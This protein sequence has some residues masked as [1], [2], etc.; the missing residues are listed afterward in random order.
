MNFSFSEG[1]HSGMSSISSGFVFGALV[2]GGFAAI[3][4]GVIVSRLSRKLL[5]GEKMLAAKLMDGQKHY[6]EVIAKHEKLLKLMLELYETGITGSLNDPRAILTKAVVD[7]ACA[8]VNAEAGSLMLMEAFT[9]KLVVSSV[10]GLPEELVNNARLA[11][12]EGIAGHVAKHGKPLLISD[13]KVNSRILPKHPEPDELRSSV[14]VPLKVKER[15]IGVLNVHTNSVEVEFNDKDIEALT[16]LAE[17]AAVLLENIEL[18]DNLQQFYFDIVQTLVQALDA[19]DSYTNEHAARARY[20]ARCV[21]TELGLPPSIVKYVEYAALMHDVGKIGVDD[22]I[23]RKPDRLTQSE[24]EVMKKHPEI[25]SKIL[26]PVSLLAPVAPMVLYHQEWYNGQG[27]PAGLSKGEIP[28]GAR[29]VA[30]IDAW[31]AMTT[32]RPYRKAMTLGEARDE[33]KKNAGT[34]FDPDVVA[35]FLQFID[36]YGL[37][38]M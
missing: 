25:G 12:G 10:K 14:S 26:S 32:D 3:I 20:Y 4:A 9:Q 15:V 7:G 35:A 38:P 30:I 36:R 1:I 27:Y 31:D 33:L 8:L 37:E 16:L 22:S 24:Y 34:Q 19:K 13:I 6:K 18:Y 29:I 21:A 5:Q 2:G 23:L 11:V 17:E 28:L